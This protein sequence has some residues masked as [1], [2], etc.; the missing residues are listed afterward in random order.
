[1]PRNKRPS[2]F[3]PLFKGRF[4]LRIDELAS[5]DP[6]SSAGLQ[7]FPESV[8]LTV[9]GDCVDAEGSV[10]ITEPLSV[11]DL[12]SA[13]D[14]IK[15]ELDAFVHQALSSMIRNATRR[16]D[17]EVQPCNDNRGAGGSATDSQKKPEE[18]VPCA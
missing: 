1:L 10:C 16:S 12:I 15:G 11:A 4:G 5:Y 17:A 13:A 6:A 8:C 7:I 18:V 3:K 9:S 14:A 2:H